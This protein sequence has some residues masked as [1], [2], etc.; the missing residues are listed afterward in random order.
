MKD[1]VVRN[2]KC[3]DANYEAIDGKMDYKE[4]LEQCRRKTECRSVIYMREAK[5]CGW[6]TDSCNELVKEIG[7]TTGPPVA[8]KI[9]KLP[10]RHV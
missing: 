5:Q 9:R 3:K 4:C 7:Q 2:G 1:F 8:D 10:H 6:Q